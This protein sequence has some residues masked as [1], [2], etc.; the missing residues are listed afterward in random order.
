MNATT[1]LPTPILART[2][3]VLLTLGLFTIGSIPA[4]GHAFP[5]AMHW[6]AHLAAY[7][8]IAFAFGLGW[9]KWPAAQIAAFVAAIGIAHEA[10]EIITH[11]HVFETEDAIVNAIGALIGV[12]IQRA[13]RQ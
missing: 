7:A 8:L 13:I 1:L 11:S 2:T 6:A 3:A 9:P 4:A 5:G 10:T 12:T